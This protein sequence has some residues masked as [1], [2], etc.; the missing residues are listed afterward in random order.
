MKIYLVRHGVYFDPENK[1]PFHLPFTLSPEGIKQIEAVADWFRSHS[2]FKI[3]IYSS[4]I[5]R[6]MQSAEII[7]SVVESPIIVEERLIEVSCPEL[8]GTV[9]PGKEGSDEVCEWEISNPTR[10]SGESIQRRT[11]EF[12]LEKVKEGEDC[13]LVSHGD[14]LTSLY[15]YLTNRPLVRCLFDKEHGEIYIKRGELVE[16]LIENNTYSVNRIKT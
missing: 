15:Y 16:V 4:P 10:E 12:F 5:K 13:I 2:V 8:Q 3:P 6:T 1:Y 11:V 14:P 9:R 7:A